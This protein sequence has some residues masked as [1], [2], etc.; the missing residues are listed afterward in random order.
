[1][2][3]EEKINTYILGVSVSGPC[4]AERDNRICLACKIPRSELKCCDKKYERVSEKLHT[5]GVYFMF[6]REDAGLDFVYIGE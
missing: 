2:S 5:P 6:V 4:V 1:M 3:C